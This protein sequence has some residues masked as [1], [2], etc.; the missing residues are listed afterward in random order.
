MSSCEHTQE[1]ARG[2]LEPVQDS[3]RM[4]GLQ[5][6]SSQ[7]S[8]LHCRTS[9]TP[10]TSTMASPLACAFVKSS[11]SPFHEWAN[12]L[13]GDPTRD[14]GARCTCPCAVA[15][16]TANRCALLQAFIST[17]VVVSTLMRPSLAF[18]GKPKHTHTHNKEKETLTQTA[19]K[20]RQ[21][22]KTPQRIDGTHVDLRV[23]SLD[24]LCNTFLTRYDR[25]A[26]VSI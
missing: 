19:K 2:S 11:P 26:E 1:V 6:V 16:H 15:L 4:A 22:S 23:R 13:A 3:F 10:T 7:T 12:K 9:E 5:T 24:C 21:K 14:R 8:A 25:H 18:Q 17:L 20:V